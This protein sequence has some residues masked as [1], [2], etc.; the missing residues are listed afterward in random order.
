MDAT[1][2]AERARR[3]E[4]V[5][6][7]ARADPA[8]VESALVAVRELAGW[9][10]ARRAVLVGKLNASAA[11]FPEATIAAVDRTSI[12]AASKVK[13]RS[14]TLAATPKLAE[15]LGDGTVT[16][17]HV[18]AVTRGAGQLDAE[19]RDELFARVDGL[20]E[21]AAAATVEQFA[22]RV[23]EEVRKLQTDDGM[24]TLTRQRASARLSTWVD[25]EGMWNLRGRFDPVTGVRL[26]AKLR[27]TIDAMFAEQT[28][29]E[30]P[31]DPSPSV[32][33][34]LTLPPVY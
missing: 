28:P 19:M 23:A 20:V 6:A 15:A 14:D 7:D 30:C 5:C 25:L 16:A 12:G 9:V 26:D 1:A 22:K 17:A 4:A 27:S 18:D 34:R 32:S 21:V 24:D 2:V 33:Q 31:T 8:A 11:S 3:V 13:A 29:V 10:E